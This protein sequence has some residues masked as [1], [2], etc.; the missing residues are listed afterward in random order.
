MLAACA[1]E[2]PSS[3]TGSQLETGQESR[4]ATAE[5]DL[6]AISAMF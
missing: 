4:L 1:I 3:P 6:L 2:C 5:K